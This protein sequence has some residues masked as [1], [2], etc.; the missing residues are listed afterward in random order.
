MKITEN[1]D[2]VIRVNKYWYQY[3]KDIIVHDDSEMMINLKPEKNEIIV[4]DLMGKR[5]NI[6]HFDNTKGV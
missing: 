1:Y 4:F 3:G 2:T 6:K 5:Q